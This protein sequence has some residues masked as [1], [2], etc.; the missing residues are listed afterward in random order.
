MSTRSRRMQVT[1]NNP[2]EKGFTS[3]K[4]KEVIGRWKTEY[5]CFCYETGESGTHHFHLY[6]KFKNPQSTDTVS[7]QFGSAHIEVTRNS[8]SQENKDYIKK[9]GAYLDSEKKATNHIETFFESCECPVDGKDNQGQRTDIDT[10]IALVQEG[11]S[12]VEIVQ[13]VPSMALRIPAVEQY[14]QA[15]WEEKGRDTVIWIF[16]TYTGKPEPEKPLM[17]TNPMILVRSIP[18]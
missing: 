2:L 12:N 10:M 15:Y 5:Y 6:V 1:C 8:S 9:E 16:G 13:A 11:A 7:K 14:R 18:L 17:F 3:E 4:I